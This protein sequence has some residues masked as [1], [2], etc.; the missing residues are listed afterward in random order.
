MAARFLGSRPSRSFGIPRAG[1]GRRLG[2]VGDY[3]RGH[4]DFPVAGVSWYEAAA[5]A[6]FAKKQIPTV[7]HWL[8]AANLGIY[9]DI[10]LF[11]NF[12]SSGPERVG[13]RRGVGAFG[14][15]DM[16][17]NVKEWC[18]NATGDRQNTPPLP[19]TRDRR[20]VGEILNRTVRAAKKLGF[21]R[22][23]EGAGLPR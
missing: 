22:E 7:Y 23:C 10:L 3:P 20:R 4:E 15:Y 12:D 5:Y 1:L 9:S 11:S 13:S 19:A 21:P 8:R 6:E 2:K 18:W 16:A 17:G 14:T